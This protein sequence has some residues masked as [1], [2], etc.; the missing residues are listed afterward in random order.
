M[1]EICQ[2]YHLNES[3]SAWQPEIDNWYSV[4][5]FRVQ[6]GR[7]PVAGD[8]S[9]QTLMDF[10]DNKLLHSTLITERGPMEFGSIYLSA[11]RALYRS[12]SSPSTGEPAQEK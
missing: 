10:L 1:N 3:H 4:E 11:K 7:L 8:D 2:K 9:Q 6:A 5:A 12:L